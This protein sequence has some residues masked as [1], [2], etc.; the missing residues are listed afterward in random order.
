MRT[1]KAWQVELGFRT[2]STGLTEL[3]AERGVREDPRERF[4]KPYLVPGGHEQPGDFVLDE[5]GDATD[6][7]CDD[8]QARLP[9]LRAPTSA[10][11]RSDSKGR[12]RRSPRAARRRR[13]ARRA[14]RRSPRARSRRSRCRS[15]PVRPVADDRGAERNIR[16]RQR[17]DQPDEILRLFQA[18]DA[19][20]PRGI[21]VERRASSRGDVHRVRNDARVPG[22]A[23][24]R[25]DAGVARALRHADEVGGQRPHEPVQPEIESRGEH[26]GT[27]RTPSRAR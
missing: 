12:R 5:L 22:R 14:A 20:E 13:P 4:A 15:R 3:P 25:R 11:P 1:A 18:A 17:S 23:C 2:F 10:C 24:S 26:R 21:A 6:G 27:A 7:A 8:R 19:H 9:S 16:E